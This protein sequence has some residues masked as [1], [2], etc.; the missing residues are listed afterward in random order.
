MNKS[1]DWKRTRE[2]TVQVTGQKPAQAL[3]AH[4]GFIAIRE[5]IAREQCPYCQS[6]NIP[7][8]LNDDQKVMG[9]HR[10]FATDYDCEGSLRLFQCPG[11]PGQ[12]ET[13]TVSGESK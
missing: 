9:I 8:I 5:I 3:A 10:R 2:A 6:F 13:E 7:V 11:T 12:G 4:V 1:A